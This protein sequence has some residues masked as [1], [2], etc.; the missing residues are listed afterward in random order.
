MDHP[1]DWTTIDWES[2][3]IHEFSPIT[4]NMSMD[5]SIEI[6]IRI[7]QWNIERGYQLKNI[8]HL[9]KQHNADILCLQELDIMCSRSQSRDI[10]KEIASELKLNSVFVPEFVEL[11]H[12]IRK[13]AVENIDE[14]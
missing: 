13:R 2:P 10:V 11:E 6:P 14:C 8:K 12:P 1:K 4:V 9:L 7:I 3:R 5:S